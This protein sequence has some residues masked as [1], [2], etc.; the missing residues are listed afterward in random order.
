MRLVFPEAEYEHE[1]RHSALLDATLCTADACRK[2][3]SA[4]LI[5]LYV[6]TAVLKHKQNLMPLLDA[7]LFSV[8]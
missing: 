4:C 3:H 1:I 2:H 7:L 6:T 5:S 8:H